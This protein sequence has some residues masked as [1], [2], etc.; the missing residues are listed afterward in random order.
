MAAKIGRY[1]F[2]SRQTA[3]GKLNKYAAI[4]PK[5]TTTASK[6]TY[7]R[8]AILAIIAAAATNSTCAG[9]DHDTKAIIGLRGLVFLGRLQK[10][11]G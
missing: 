8:A 2:N 7:N 6:S 1:W 3:A 10:P 4:D 11:G 5:Q 9:G